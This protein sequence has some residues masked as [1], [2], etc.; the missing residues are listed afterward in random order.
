MRLWV[1]ARRLEG[2]R[3]KAATAA[4]PPSP[5]GWP[6]AVHDWLTTALAEANADISGIRLQT[7]GKRRSGGAAPWRASAETLLADV[8]QPRY[9]SRARVRAGMLLSAH[10]YEHLNE[11]GGARDM[12]AWWRCCSARAAGSLVTRALLQRYLAALPLLPWAAFANHQLEWSPLGHD[13]VRVRAQCGAVE[14]SVFLEFGDD[15]L[16]A[17]AY[18]LGRP[19]IEEQGVPERPWRQDFSAYQRLS[20][21]YVPCRLT[22]AW[23]MAESSGEA[24]LTTWQGELEAVALL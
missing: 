11:H 20:G 24:W 2:R 8:T 9:A 16:P 3:R 21:A 13:T 4:Q 15:G 23:D 17:R 19:R 5:Q 1:W 12:R 14:G 18:A 10:Q 7:W 22:S 6:Q